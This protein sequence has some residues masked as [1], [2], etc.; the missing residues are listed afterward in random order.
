MTSSGQPIRK[1][2]EKQTDRLATS[3]ARLTSLAVDSLLTQ[4]QRGPLGTQSCPVKMHGMGKIALEPETAL[5]VLCSGWHPNILSRQN[6]CCSGR[7]LRLRA[8]RRRLRRSLCRPRLWCTWRRYFDVGSV[9]PLN[10]SRR[11]H[12]SKAAKAKRMANLEDAG[13]WLNYRERLPLVTV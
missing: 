11:S 8:S 13:R 2:A 4:S 10:A 9:K 6:V 3:I 7:R 12:R 5:R 1:T